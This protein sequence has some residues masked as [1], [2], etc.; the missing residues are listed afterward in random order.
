LSAGEARLAARSGE[1]AMLAKMRRDGLRWRGLDVRGRRGA[2]VLGAGGAIDTIE[3]SFL[4]Q[5]T[6]GLRHDHPNPPASTDSCEA[7][8][9]ALLFIDQRRFDEIAASTLDWAIAMLREAK[10]I[11]GAAPADDATVSR[12][13]VAFIYE[14][15][16]SRNPRRPIA[17]EDLVDFLLENFRFTIRREPASGPW[18]EADPPSLTVFPMP[19]YLTLTARERKQG[20]K[21]P[22]QA[23]RVDFGADHLIDDDYGAFIGR[24]FAQLLQDAAAAAA[25]TAA[26]ERA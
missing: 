7:Q 20:D 10:S 6:A 11:H 4:P 16:A 23:Y 13:E 17:L 5:I 25:A 24:Y 2:L 26:A 9:E 12:S 1:A 19:P 18:S 8:L 21:D 3:L 14:D 22:T 15:L